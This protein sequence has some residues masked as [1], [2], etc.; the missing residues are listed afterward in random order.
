MGTCDCLM[1]Q[2]AVDRH[3]IP[4]KAA[5]YCFIFI[6][7]TSAVPSAIKLKQFVEF[8]GRMRPS[9]KTFDRKETSSVQ[10]FVLAYVLFNVTPF[11][12]CNAS[13]PSNFEKGSSSFATK[14]AVLILACISFCSW[15]C[16]SL[17]IFENDQAIWL[18]EIAFPCEC[19]LS[20][21]RIWPLLMAC[22]LTVSF[23]KLEHPFRKSVFPATLEYTQHKSQ[24]ITFFS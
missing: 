7:L 6:P 5:N 23:L 18:S 9:L 3:S 15:D 12:L 16:M 17:F 20:L 11:Y 21:A 8:N 14:Y 1:S 2:H 19:D 24:F 13:K 4:Y 22:F 10:L